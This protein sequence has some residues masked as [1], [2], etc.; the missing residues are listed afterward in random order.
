MESE[1]NNASQE[2][3]IDRAIAET[4]DEMIMTLIDMVRILLIQV[5]L[6]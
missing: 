3:E 6:L 1:P 4:N 5:T 2:T